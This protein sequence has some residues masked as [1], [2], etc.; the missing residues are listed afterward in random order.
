[1]GLKPADAQSA[2][3]LKGFGSREWLTGVLDPAHVAGLDYFGGTKFKTGRMVKFVQKDVA[4]FDADK[5]QQLEKVIKA[6]SAEAQLP[7]QA[8]ADKTDAA[9]IAQGAELFRSEAMRCSECHQF[10]KKDEDATAPELT[11]WGSSE[12]LVAVIKN[13]KHPR[14]YGSRNDRMPAF[15]E[16]GILDDRQ[17]AMLVKW[18]RGEE[19]AT[20]TAQ[21]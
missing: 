2:S 3:D 13:P 17:V 8:N 12:W 1:M 9:I 15:G 18:L 4:N 6:V 20:A 21:R 14:F 11:G 19:T 16:E 7:A 10:H 5:K